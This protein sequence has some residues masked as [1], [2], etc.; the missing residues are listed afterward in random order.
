MIKKTEGAEMGYKELDTWPS[1]SN[2]ANRLIGQPMFS[3]MVKARKLEK[4]GKKIHHFEIGDLNF[5]TPQEAI[6]AAKKALDDGHTHYTDS[7]GIWDLRQTIVERVKRDYGFEPEIDQV[8]ISPANGIIDLVI[9]CVAN[10]GDE[11]IM[12]DPGFPSYLAAAHYAGMGSVGVPLKETN[13]FNMNP[14]DIENKITD[15]TKLIIINSP[16]NPTGSV[17][18]EDDV[19]AIA[20]IS[21]ER[22]IFLLSDEAYSE[23][24]Y[25][26][27][28]HSPSVYDACRERVVILGSMSKNYGMAGWR[29]GYAIGPKVLISKMGLMLQ[30]MISCLPGFTQIGAQAVLKS[31]D[32]LLIKRKEILKKRRNVLV[33]LLNSLPGITCDLP[34]GAIYVFPNI[35]GTGMNSQEF[36]DRMLNA[37]VCVL[38]GKCFGEYGE[39]YVRMCFGSVSVEEIEDSIAKMK[40]V[41]YSGPREVNKNKGKPE[42]VR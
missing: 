30:T 3:L 11:I 20:D 15:K 14:L 7:M 35:Q 22:Q 18:T 4:A 10:P 27:A 34:K 31:C 28:H 42:G 1:L 32:E 16:N 21:R 12:P 36:S 39:G 25:S 38:P 24:V 6:V 37:G 33:E 17:M 26:G 13:R 41:I 8:L 29:I 40:T 9:R 2:M 5:G 23:L 19:K